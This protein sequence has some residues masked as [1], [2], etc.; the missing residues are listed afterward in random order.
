MSGTGVGSTRSPDEVR[1]VYPVREDSRLLARFARPRPGDDV[2]EIGCGRGFA[3]LVS[4]R[5]GAHRV[6]GTDRNPTALRLLFHR[7]REEGLPIEAVRTDLAA[8]LR[9]FDLVLANPP[10]LPTTRANR[11]ED[12]WERL[13][14]DGGPD[15]C[16]VLARLLDTLPS[17]LAPRGRA[18]VLVSS[19]QSHRR[20]DQLR[21]RWRQRGGGC[22][23]VAQER[24]GDETLS[25]WCLRR[26][27][28]RTGRSIPGT[29]G[30]RPA[31]RDRRSAS[32]RDAGSGKTS[33]R[34]AA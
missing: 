21:S 24:W 11:E 2:L 15:G 33:V 9:T 1:E 26:A 17:H 7:A 14:L 25:I 29:G 23:T 32:S 6:V 4:A 10:Y 31:L 13:A 18:F 3:S 34:D 19:L 8:G 28:R 20:V 30:R 5:H 22:R 16:R 12:P 27:L